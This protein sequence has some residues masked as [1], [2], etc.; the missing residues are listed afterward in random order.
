MNSRKKK[1]NDGDWTVFKRIGRPNLLD[2]GMLKKIKDIALGTRMAEGVISKR[3]L[4][5]TASGVIRRNNPNLL[6]EY[7][8]YIVLTNK[9]SRGVLEKITWNKLK[10]STGKVDSSPQFLVEE[11]FT[12]QRNI[13]ALVSEYDIT[14]SLITNIDQIPLS[15]VNAEKYTFNFKGAKNI[16]IKGVDDKR[17]ITVTFHVSCNEE[18]LPIQ[19]IYS[20][21]V[22][23]KSAEVLFSTF[24]FGNV[25]RKSFVKQR[26]I[27]LIL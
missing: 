21:K 18:F 20:G 2:S 8:G 27:C 10:S 16:P 5:S 1:D 13:S 11:N 17:Q 25:H 14:P 23:M 22:R 6:K 3:Q 7:G 12:F 9:W 15:Y 26:E 4:I 19:L 24:F